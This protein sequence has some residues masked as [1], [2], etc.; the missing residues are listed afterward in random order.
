MSIVQGT[1]C[2]LGDTRRASQTPIPGP[3]LS[4]GA[5]AA[6]PFCQGLDDLVGEGFDT[7]GITRSNDTSIFHDLLVFPYCPALIVS[8][9][10]DLYDV[11]LRPFAS[12]VS[13][14]S[15]GA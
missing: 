9:L 11:A 15:H 10:I 2:G 13:I 12:P 5:P 7:A 6:F 8:V 14:R 4:R 3:L 1:I